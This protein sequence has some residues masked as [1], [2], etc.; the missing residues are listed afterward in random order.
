MAPSTPR[1]P[2]TPRKHVTPR[3]RKRIY[4]LMKSGMT[5]RDVAKLE[6]VK[7][8]TC[9]GI[10]TRFKNQ[11]DGVTRTRTGRPPV[12]SAQSKRAILRALAKDPFIAVADIQ[13]N[14]ASDVSLSTLRRF[15]SKEGIMHVQSARRPL[16]TEQVAENRLE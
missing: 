14:H 11:D 16:L 2:K 15:L 3:Q 4:T 6:G 9:R 10:V 5:S 7:P 8:S 13:K 1:K 12:L